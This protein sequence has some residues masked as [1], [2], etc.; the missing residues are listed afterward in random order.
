MSGYRVGIDVGGTFTDLICVTPEGR[1][2]LD[3]TATTPEDQ[4]VGV[5]N[6]LALLAQREGREVDE[7]CSLIEVLVHGTT[8][9][10]NTMIEM[11]GAITGMLVT[12]GHRDEIEMRRVHK[13]QIWDPS[14]PAPV[15]I[16]RRR[17]RIPIPQR[18]DYLGE[19]LLALD[20]TAVRAG[21]QRLK[22]L[23]VES[24]AVVFLFSFV[25]PSHEL[26][27]REIILEEYPEVAHISLSHEVMARGPEFERTSTTLVN[28][29]T[30]PRITMYVEQLEQK[31]Q[32]AGCTAPLL[33]MQATG[34]VM[35]PSYV[36]HRAVTL[37]GSG[38][39]GGVIGAA[40]AAAEA[41][42]TEFVAIDMGGT[43]FDICLV[44]GG[45]PEVK[46]DWNW[47]YRYYIGLPM[48]DIQCIG[49]GGGSIARVRQG[50]LLV[51]PESAGAQ[52][53]PAC[54]GRGGT[55]PTVTDA[56]AVLGYLRPTGFADGRMDL[57]LE[58][59][60]EAIR[61]EVAGPLG[62]DLIAAAWGIERIVNANMAAATRKVLAGYGADARELS[63]I[64]YGG[65][66]AVHAWAIAEELGVTRVLI[67]RAAPVFS[68]LGLLI[69]DYRVDL[70]LAHV[71]PIRLVDPAQLHRMLTDLS[72]EA[73]AELNPAQL[74]PDQIEIQLFVQMAYP[75]Q[76]F[77]MS[78]PVPSAGETSEFLVELIERFHDQNLAE[79][80]FA[81]RENSP[82]LRGVR[83]LVTGSTPHPPTLAESAGVKD[84]EGA[85][86]G[87]RPVHFGSGF[88]ES[89][90]FDGGL[91]GAGIRVTGPALIEER[92]T[93]IV[94][95]PGWTA[96]LLESSSFELSKD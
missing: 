65:N 5:M 79:R 70:Q 35:P 30:A 7:F 55:R 90:T 85:R 32:S 69:A 2:L 25:D 96:E 53:G 76:N 48:V 49:A 84:L 26:R 27:A 83:A 45:L 42:V 92:F 12:E 67:P 43:S 62:V 40:R 46:A 73:V 11:D 64:A 19:E 59:A 78:V 18:M 75:G 8:T 16:A 51:G 22:Q 1:V 95:P 68:A 58:A 24:I 56:D 60:R 80:G 4:S 74:N 57:D 81:F 71:S 33:L 21:V 29:Y 61:T 6:G 34:G 94:I 63:L 50:T 15:P 36:S 82:L 41:G 52:P 28:A 47:R 14:Y 13:E 77:D 66:G 91:L 9:A 10:D 89:P 72:A 3:K 17:A 37:L 31:L 20:E 38:P 44:R 54:Y 39:T 86:T 88:V 87:Y 93:V 23:G